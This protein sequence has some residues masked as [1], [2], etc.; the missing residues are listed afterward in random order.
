MDVEEYLVS[1]IAPRQ[2]R[3]LE[4]NESGTRD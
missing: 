4:V 2:L 1:G 3:W